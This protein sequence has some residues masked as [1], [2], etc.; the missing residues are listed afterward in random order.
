LLELLDYRAHSEPT[1]K[2]FTFLTDGE[3]EQDHLTNG[4]LDKQARAIG[5]RL[6]ELGVVGERVLLLY[7]TGL[8]FIAAFFGCFYAGAVA[9]PVYP[10]PAK[11]NMPRLQG[12]VE[13]AQITIALTTTPLSAKLRG[14]LEKTPKLAG[15]GWLNTDEI[16]PNESSNWKK[17]HVNTENL[18][19]I[20]YTASSTGRPKGGMVRLGKLL[21][22]QQAIQRAVG[23]KKKSIP[24]GWLPQFHDL[25]LIG[26][27][28]QPL[29]LGFPH[30]FLSPVAFFAETCPLASSPFA[31]QSDHE[32]GS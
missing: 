27:V 10:P 21:H 18:A 23:Y 30:I 32:W 24:V 9:V 8:E 16:D 31:I 22:N 29:F 2:A 26:Q 17:P 25:G 12:V 3:N 5:M 15:V 4:E 7:P 6:Q 13:D 20:Q 14:R 1:M 28:L 11:E 19:L